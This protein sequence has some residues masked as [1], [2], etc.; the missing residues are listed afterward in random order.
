M[1]GRL[2][3]DDDH[4]DIP[5]DKNIGNCNDWYDAVCYTMLDFVEYLMLD[6]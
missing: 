4:P 5:E 2:R 1:S 3:W 6:R